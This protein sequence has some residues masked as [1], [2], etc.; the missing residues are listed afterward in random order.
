[1][2]WHKNVNNIALHLPKFPQS[3]FCNR[4]KNTLTV[5]NW[6]RSAGW[7]PKVVFKKV[8]CHNLFLEVCSLPTKNYDFRRAHTLLIITQNYYLL[9]LIW[10]EAPWKHLFSTSGQ[11]LNPLLLTSDFIFLKELLEHTCL[12][13]FR[14]GA[15]FPFT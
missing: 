8:L 11:D 9:V 13:V 2:F 6:A 10:V 5:K 15:N 14:R 3:I 4:G 7:N 1:M 12:T